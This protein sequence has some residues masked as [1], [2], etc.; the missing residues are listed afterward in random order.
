M[1][2]QLGYGVVEADSGAAALDALSRGEVYDLVL[3]DL[4]MPGLNGIETVQRAR[5]RWP[6]L[7]VLYVT[8]YAEFAAPERRTADDPLIKKPFRLEELRA[9]VRR[10]IRKTATG[11]AKNVVPLR[12]RAQRGKDVSS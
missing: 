10:A 7:R 9:E 1:L 12:Q 8:G 11:E 5:E 4:A 3:I 6:G 2:R